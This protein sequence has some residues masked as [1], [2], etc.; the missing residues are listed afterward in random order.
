MHE[1]LIVR[2]IL[3]DSSK[4]TLTIQ[5]RE[6]DANIYCKYMYKYLNKRQWNQCIIVRR[7]PLLT[8]RF[9]CGDIFFRDAMI[10]L[11]ILRQVE[12]GVRDIGYNR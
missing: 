6:T 12:L 8:S 1:Y 10:L 11:R 2:V 9:N 7:I 5:A 4:I 3:L